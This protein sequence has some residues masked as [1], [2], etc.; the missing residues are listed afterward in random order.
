M[1]PE[2]ITVNAVGVCVN[3]AFFVVVQSLIFWFIASKELKRVML[4]TSGVL[5]NARRNLRQTEGQDVLVTTLDSL[6]LSMAP[7]AS[8]EEIQEEEKRLQ[9]ANRTVLMQY[10]GSYLLLIILVLLGL[11][12][13]NYYK[14][15]PFTKAHWVGIALVVL[16]Y[17]TEALLLAF[18]IMPCPFPRFLSTGRHGKASGNTPASLTL[19]PNSWTLGARPSNLPDS[20]ACL[21]FFIS[22]VGPRG[23]AS[24]RSFP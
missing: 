7:N 8:P 18:V 19:P 23:P 20:G 9:R 17:V 1:D 15:R 22:C 4:H 12:A 13:F 11:I 14:K 6:I 2:F 3:V 24:P 16:A 10:A 5:V 21:Y